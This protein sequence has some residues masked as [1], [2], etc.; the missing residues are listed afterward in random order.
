MAESLCNNPAE[1]LFKKKSHFI[2]CSSFKEVPNIK[3]SN[4]IFILVK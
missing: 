3:K 4:N 2:I 1:T